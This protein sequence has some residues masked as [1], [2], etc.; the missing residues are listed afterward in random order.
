MGV[1]VSPVTSALSAASAE[2]DEERQQRQRERLLTQEIETELA[3]LRRERAA[4]E[5]QVDAMLATR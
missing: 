4:I 1:F 5:A 3:L 2:L